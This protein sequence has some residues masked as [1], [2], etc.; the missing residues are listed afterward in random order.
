MPAC[1]VGIDI[2]ATNL[3]AGL[4]T[5]QGKLITQQVVRLTKKDKSEAGIV[6]AVAN[7]VERLA[8]E[9]RIAVRELLGVGIGVAG[10][11]EARAG[12]ITDSPNFPAWKNFPLA[13]RLSQALH[14][15]VTIEN[16]V[17]AVA[18][19]EHFAGATKGVPNFLC[20]ALG[21]GLG[22]AIFLD[23]RMWRG[24]EGMAGEVGHLCV[25]P[26][27]A[28]CGCGSRG[29]LETVASQTGLVRRIK[30]DN[31]RKVLDDVET[32]SAIPYALAVLAQNGDP[33]AQA[34]WDEVGRALGIALGGLLNTLNVKIVLLGGGLSRSFPLFERALRENLVAHSFP[35]VSR[36]VEFRTSQLWEEAGI[37]GAAAHLLNTLKARRKRG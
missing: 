18:L 14:L 3:K 26:D 19:G 12:L 32:E 11:I 28:P 13:E 35:A 8:Q 2:G 30:A 1:C 21:T 33:Q 6:A 20:M 25:Y 29:C 17:N 37:I 4:L 22:G 10:V 7:M 24:V 16:D 15:P 31:F 23:G 34:Y 36:G 9:N 27:G 5:R